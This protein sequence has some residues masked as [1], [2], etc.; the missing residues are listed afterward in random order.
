MRVVLRDEN[1]KRKLEG[2]NSICSFNSN[3]SYV[4]KCDGYWK[5]NERKNVLN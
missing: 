4:S 2:G 3:F 5:W 1:W